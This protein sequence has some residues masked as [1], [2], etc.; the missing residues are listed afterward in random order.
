ME[1]FAP[2]GSIEDVMRGQ[3]AKGPNSRHAGKSRVAIAQL[4]LAVNVDGLFALYSF[5]WAG[6]RKYIF[7]VNRNQNILF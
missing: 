6:K 2:R 1:K 4:K 7:F 3:Q 5:T